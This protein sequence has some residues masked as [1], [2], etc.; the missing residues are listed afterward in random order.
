MPRGDRLSP[1]IRGAKFAIGALVVFVSACA[2][3]PHCAERPASAGLADFHAALGDLEAGK[4]RTINILHLG[5]SHIALDHLTGVLRGDWTRTYGD[6]G[7]GLP[8]GNPY[9]Y[10]A[11]QGYKVSMTG[12]WVAASSLKAGATGPFGISGYRISATS[13]AARTS[14]EKEGGAFDEVEIEAMGGPSTGSLMVALD[15]AVSLRLSTRAPRT[16]LVRLRV[17]AASAHRVEIRPAGDGEIALLGWALIT[18]RPGIRYD[19]YGISG[20]TLDVVGHWDQGVV[21]AQIAALRPDLVILG[22]GTNEGFNDRLDL[23]A[24]AAKLGTLIA[25]LK[26]LSPHASI[27]VLG[28]LDGARKAKSG[29]AATC[30][31]GWT[32]PPKL[33]ALRDVQKSV[34]AKQDAFYFDLSGVMDGACGIARWA[35]AHPPLAWPDRVHLRTDG[36]RRA[37]AALLRALMPHTKTCGQR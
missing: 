2:A 18:G 6:A 19:S 34:A 23:H 21:D 25:R 36:A 37:G 13:A 14:I 26:R 24:Y 5:D 3:E 28:P 27:A 22:Y 31:G 32:T 35:D 7:R 17:P 33:A 16:G 15:G 4:R 1:A 10:Y 9:R 12:P 20:A 11:P 8:P 29:E 30:G